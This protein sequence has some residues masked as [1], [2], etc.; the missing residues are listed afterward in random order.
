MSQT[1]PP[2]AELLANC[3]QS[4]VHLET[5]DVYGVANEDADYA[6]WLA[7]HRYSINDRSSW[8]TGFHDTVASAV[9]RGVVVRRARIVS[10]PTSDY[11][12]FEH[13]HTPQNLAAG[14]DVRWLPRPMAVDLLV[15]VND[16]WLF[17]DRLIRVHHFA[18][19]GA[20]VRDELES[21]P[22]VVKRHAESFEAVWERAIPH[23]DYRI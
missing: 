22:D 13:A 12:R 3:R 11:I 5:R 23:G 1:V 9:G 17:D 2:F 15:P 10:E 20:H 6:A 4:A 21:R 7:G 18:G 16:F 14:E 19:T 8:W